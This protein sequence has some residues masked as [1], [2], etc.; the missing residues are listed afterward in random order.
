MKE[1]PKKI[2]TPPRASPAAVT[3]AKEL[4]KEATSAEQLLWKSLRDRR[5]Q[6]CK[7]R[8]QHPIGKYVLDF[9]SYE[10]KLA[11]ELDGS[12]H[13]DPQ[14]A[15]LWREQVI[16]TRGIRFLRF[17]NEEVDHNL[18]YVLERISQAIQ[19]QRSAS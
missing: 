14:E 12:I 19:M 7:F 18:N 17:R 1:L 4:R 10:A 5:L 15:D 11:I 13:D 16:G 8:R 6:N 3:R 9:F 2:W